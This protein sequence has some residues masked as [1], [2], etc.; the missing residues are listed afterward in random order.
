LTYSQWD[1]THRFMLAVSY[2]HDWTGNGVAT[3]FGLFYNAQSGRPFSYMVNGDINGD[4][5]SDNDLAYIPR[6]A[7][8]VIL[9]N[10][11][12]S[13]VLTDKN[14]KEYVDMMNYINGN[15]YMKEHKGQISERSGP[16]EP[17]AHTVD[18]RLNQEIPT[19]DGQKIEITLDI[20]NVL[21]LLNSDWG[22]VR[23]TG[24]NQTVNFMRFHS[25]ETT[26]PDAGKPRYQWTG[27]SSPFVADNLLSRYQMQLGIRYTL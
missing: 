23:N 3:S 7:N 24:V 10:S 4:G 26:G 16:R 18:L 25:I 20:L 9:M 14:A 2:R 17:W 22:W 11:A 15:S 27:A 13:A 21:N 8:D 19:F 5:R 12:G 1:R 6:D